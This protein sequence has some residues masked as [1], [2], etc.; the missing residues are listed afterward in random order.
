MAVPECSLEDLPSSALGLR[1]R[2][3]AILGLPSVMLMDIS[4]G[5][6]FP[7]KECF[8]FYSAITQ[9]MENPCVL[10]VSCVLLAVE[11]FVWYP[12]KEAI[13]TSLERPSSG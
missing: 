1:S 13:F 3:I 8:A 4:I 5:F 2:F 11:L 12:T 10:Y 6:S 9:R 7:K